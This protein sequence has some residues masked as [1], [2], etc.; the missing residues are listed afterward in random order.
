MNKECRKKYDLVFITNMPAF[1]KIRLWNEI[2]IKKNILAIFVNPIDESRN[3][4]FLSGDPKFDF[5]SLDSEGIIKKVVVI[6]KLLQSV[7]Y[8]RLIIGGWD[9]AASLIIPF[10]TKKNK[11]C[12]LCES[13]IFEYRPAFLKDCIKRLF[14]RRISIG[15][16]AGLSHGRLLRKL[17]FKGK[18]VYTGGC[19]LL[20]YQP[21]PKYE[22][23]SEVKNFLY[24]GR[25]IEVKNIKLLISVFQQM[26]HLDL[27]I[28][29]FGEQE[30]ELRAMGACDNIHFIGAIN[31]S[32]LH[33]YYRKADVFVLPSKS[34]TWGLV[35]EEALNCGT[36]VLVS[37]MV[38]CKD[39]L[40]TEETG[41]VFDHASEASLRLAIEQMCNIEYYNKLRAGVSRLDFFAR[42]QQQINAF[43]D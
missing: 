42:A 34:E 22:F 18:L 14:L 36:P 17:G 2:S 13:S 4:D 19:G 21:T 7:E 38:G 16:P 8:K 20:N 35:V 27:Y 41:L 15:Y 31:N 29:G 24:V 33:S 32:D 12:I 11:N 1:Y 30:K 40:V 6:I 23:R 28:I 39:D 3:K 10:L 43:L 5:I 26:P 37:D 9:N 25:L